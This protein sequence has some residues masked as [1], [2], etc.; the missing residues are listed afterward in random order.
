[1][2]CDP[3]RLNAFILLP[4]SI[5]EGNAPLPGALPQQQQEITMNMT[6]FK[7]FLGGWFFFRAIR[8]RPK[9]W[10]VL[11]VEI[12]QTEENILRIFT[13]SISVSI[14]PISL[15]KFTIPSIFEG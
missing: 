1:L 14:Y 3:S 15:P 9:I 8:Y 6:S 12:I 4:L 5:P 2:I 7:F 10:N 13:F 11:C